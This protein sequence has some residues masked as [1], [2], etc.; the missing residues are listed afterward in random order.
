MRECPFCVPDEARIISRCNCAIAI[1]DQFPVSEGHTL[2]VPNAHVRSIF[3][4]FAEEQCEVWSF[5]GQVRNHLAHELTV[6]AFNIGVNDGKNAGRTIDH[7][8]I[9]V[10]PRRPG[11]VT[12]PR[13]G[14]RLIIPERARYW[15]GE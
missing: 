12:D 3:D 5:V 11:D 8:H 1:R 2:I 7:A 13:G 15:E 14:I 4:L 10:I 6:D 9:H